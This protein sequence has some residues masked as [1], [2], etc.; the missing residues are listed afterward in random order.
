MTPSTILAWTVGGWEILLIFF[1]ILLLFG[2][3]RLPELARSLGLAK[4]EFSKA[5]KEATEE[6][7]KLKDMSPTDSS[8]KNNDSSKKV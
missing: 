5:T 1:V 7:E 8:S 2:A 4:K 6:F 3:K